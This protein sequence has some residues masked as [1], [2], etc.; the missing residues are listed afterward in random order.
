VEKYRDGSSNKWATKCNI[1]GPTT[2]FYWSNPRV[3]LVC[4]F[5]G[6]A[7]MLSAIYLEYENVMPVA[8]GLGVLAYVVQSNPPEAKTTMKEALGWTSFPYVS[9][10]TGLGLLG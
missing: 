6:A 5:V 7:T 4:G 9:F 8:M 3:G 10:T 1:E 2:G